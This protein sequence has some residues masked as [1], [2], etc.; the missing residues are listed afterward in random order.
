MNIKIS[1]SEYPKIISFYINDWL[2]GSQ[3]KTKKLSNN[4]SEKN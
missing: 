4:M 2:S 1:T 3:I